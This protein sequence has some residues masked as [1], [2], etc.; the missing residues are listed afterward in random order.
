MSAPRRS[1]LHPF[2][3]RFAL[4]FGGATLA[5]CAV[6]MIWMRTRVPTPAELTAKVHARF[7][8]VDAT[9]PLTSGARVPE[10]TAL[11]VRARNRLGRSVHI[12]A[13]ALDPEGQLHWYLPARGA[14]AATR[15]ASDDT[16]RTLPSADR[17]LPVGPIRLVVVHAMNPI[18]AE[19]I[20]AEVARWWRDA[21]GI[22]GGPP[23]TLGDARE[24][25]WI[26]IVEQ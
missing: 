4:L 11:V 17:R 12:A 9:R 26:D 24:S 21:Q 10:G 8:P 20:E 3:Q 5:I 2:S 23:L 6:W 22:R 14:G 16:E 7:A 25:T 13:F 19:T 18:K 15:V 1:G